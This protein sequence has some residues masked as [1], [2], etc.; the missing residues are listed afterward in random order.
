MHPTN[1]EFG[2]VFTPTSC[3]DHVRNFVPEQKTLV[4]NGEKRSLQKDGEARNKVYSQ[5][6]RLPGQIELHLLKF[7][8]LLDSSEHCGM[9]VGLCEMR[10]E[11]RLETSVRRKRLLAYTEASFAYLA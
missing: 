7:V 9:D 4:L 8:A 1:S 6:E 5:N 11:M 3:L 2:D 10:L